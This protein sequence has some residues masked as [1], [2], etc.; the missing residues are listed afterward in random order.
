MAPKIA[1]AFYTALAEGDEPRRIEL[2]TGF[3]EPL[4]ALRDRVPG[5]AVSLIKAGVVEGG[6]AVGGV[7]PPLVD[8]TP[9][10]LTRLQEILARGDELVG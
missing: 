7:R 4:V 8:P 5:Y 6:L 9:E 1:T 10:D 2:L 3:Y